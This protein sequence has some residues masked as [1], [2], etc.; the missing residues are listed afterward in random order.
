MFEGRRCKMSFG[1]SNKKNI[2]KVE[3]GFS[4]N[5]PPKQTKRAT[6][7]KPLQK[8]V[9]NQD[10]W[11]ERIEKNPGV[12]CRFS[13]P[14][15]VVALYEGT[16]T[17]TCLG[18]GGTFEELQKREVVVEKWAVQNGFRPLVKLNKDH[19]LTKTASSGCQS[20]FKI[21]RKSEYCNIYDR[22]TQ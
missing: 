19:F 16:K 4:K 13:S 14:G 22:K 18:Q 6:I 15:V 7:L 2:L 17:W 5:L 10:A 8:P 3:K 9:V 12:V 11:Q 21:A 20:G 1:R